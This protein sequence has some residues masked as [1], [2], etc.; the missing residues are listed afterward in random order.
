MIDLVLPKKRCFGAR[1]ITPI[2]GCGGPEIGPGSEVLTPGRSRSG[3]S[4]G[5]RTIDG[6]GRRGTAGVDLVGGW[7]VGRLSDSW[8]NIIA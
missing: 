1:Q 6:E 8:A 7:P 3:E 2:F 4:R 5:D